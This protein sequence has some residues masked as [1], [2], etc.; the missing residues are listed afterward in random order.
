M[1]LI[2]GEGHT[3]QFISSHTT[4]IY[5]LN[6]GVAYNDN[7]VCNISL[8]HIKRFICYKYSHTEHENLKFSRKLMEEC[9]KHWFVFYFFKLYYYRNIM[10][11]SLRFHNCSYSTLSSYTAP[12]RRNYSSLSRVDIEHILWQ[13]S[14]YKLNHY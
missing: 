7:K 13:L 3:H 6:C 8:Q 11:Y 2:I 5:V 14:L 9:S 12:Y 10:Q 4:V 1:Q